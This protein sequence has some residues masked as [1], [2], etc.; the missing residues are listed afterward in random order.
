MV[1]RMA[2]LGVEDQMGMRIGTTQ[3]GPKTATAPATVCGE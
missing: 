2:P 1:P 3:K